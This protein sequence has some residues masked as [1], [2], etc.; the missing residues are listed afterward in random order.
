MD[1]A[2]FIGLLVADTEVEQAMVKYGNT[3]ALIQK[4]LHTPGC[5]RVRCVVKFPRWHCPRQG[6]VRPMPDSTYQF[7][8]TAYGGE[9]ASVR[10]FAP[11][12]N[13]SHIAALFY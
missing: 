2:F 8:Y 10:I 1:S 7:V 11:H 13:P 3:Q 12:Y 9:T 5:D 6:Y 4:A